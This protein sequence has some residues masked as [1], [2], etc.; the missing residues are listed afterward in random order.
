M[1]NNSNHK[2]Y[3][4]WKLRGFSSPEHYEGFKYFNREDDEHDILELE[5]Y[6]GDYNN[7]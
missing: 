3:D 4:H 7:G 2:N 6:C 1:K 5:E